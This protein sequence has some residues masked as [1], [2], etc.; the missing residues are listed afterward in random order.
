M[1]NKDKKL[2]KPCEIEPENKSWE[3]GGRDTKVCENGHIMTGIGFD[4]CCPICEGKWIEQKCPFLCRELPEC[5][6]CLKAGCKHK[7]ETPQPPKTNN[8]KD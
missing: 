5:D 8:E 4:E 6:V 1:E 7:P 3:R 2:N